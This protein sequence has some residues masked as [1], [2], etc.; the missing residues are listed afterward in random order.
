MCKDEVD[1]EELWILSGF[2]DKVVYHANMGFSVEEGE[3]II[4]DEADEYIYND[5][6]AF[7]GFIGECMCVCLTAT[8]GGSGKEAAEKT[9]LNHIG[10][11]IFE[12]ALFSE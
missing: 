2:K 1:F 5:P 7:L 8:T 4:F 11:K 12:N 10:L 6:K 3:L 9:I